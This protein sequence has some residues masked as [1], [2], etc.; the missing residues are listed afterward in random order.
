MYARENRL[1]F[2]GHALRNAKEGSAQIEA[3][4]GEHPVEGLCELVQVSRTGY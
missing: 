3:I 1:K 2:A 4:K